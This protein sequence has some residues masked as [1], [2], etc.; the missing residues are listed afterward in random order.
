[1]AIKYGEAPKQ[2]CTARVYLILNISKCASRKAETSE[3]QLFA[4][5]V[6]KCAVV[7]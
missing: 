6:L 1:M 7:G 3:F 4:V 2:S 5:D